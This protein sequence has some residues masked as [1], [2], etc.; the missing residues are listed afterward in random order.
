MTS[1]RSDLPRPEY[2]QPQFA[3]SLWLNLNG[4]WKFAFDYSDEA[5]SQ[6][7]YDG[8][9]LP[10]LITVPFTYQNPLSG[11]NDKSVHEIVWYA[12]TFDLPEVFRGRDVL[13]NFGAVDYAA[14][15]WVNGH[16]VG[17]NRG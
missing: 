5:L 8:R 7:W 1:N 15:I 4:E 2:P 3:R 16:E 6:S 13:L 11:I 12:R 10:L 14:S 9:E 17:H